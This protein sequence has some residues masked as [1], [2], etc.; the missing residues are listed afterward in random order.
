MEIEAIWLKRL[1]GISILYLVNR[2][3]MT[4]AIVSDIYITLPGNAVSD[5]RF[6]S[7][8]YA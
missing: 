8:F 6:A 1:T 2:Y 3:L 5:E 7:H 4:V